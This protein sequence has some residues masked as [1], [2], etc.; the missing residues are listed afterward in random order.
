MLKTREIVLIALFVSAIW[1]VVFALQSDTSAYY[2]ICETNQY[3]DKERCAPHHILYVAAWYIGYWFNAAS[4]II[5]AFATAAIGYFTYTLKQS[6]DRLW[7]AGEKQF[8]HAR[9]EA[10]SASLRHMRGENQLQEQIEILRQSAVTSAEHARIAGNALT[11]LERPYV[12]IFGVRGIK[13]DT[14]SRD[15]YVEY[16]VANY[17]KMPA[18]IEAP[19][20]G[21]AK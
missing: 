21:F 5:T 10:L 12:F 11:N 13:Q 3:T 6:T 7:E 20:I 16:T 1:V 9:E 8:R 14:D 4:A 15:F 18:I 17:G 19:H 2:Q